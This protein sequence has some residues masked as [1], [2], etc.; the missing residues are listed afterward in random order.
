MAATPSR[1]CARWRASLPD[2]AC[3][4]RSR[5]RA[6]NLTRAGADVQSAQPLVQALQRMGMPL[7]GALAPT[8]YKTTAQAWLNSD[9][10][11]DRFNFALQLANGRMNGVKFDSGRVVA[12]SL[13][14]NRE[15]RRLRALRNTAAGSDVALPLAEDAL[16][17]GRVSRQTEQAIR[18]QRADP[19]LA[20][21]RA[22]DPPRPPP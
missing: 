19:K 15:P 13:F 3:S 16:V 21:A 10:L 22:L 9:A 17:P 6:S 12:A 11:L 20:G 4:S 1:M 18:K 5:A 2:G 8:G 14:A 7:Y